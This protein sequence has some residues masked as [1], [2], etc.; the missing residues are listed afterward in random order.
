MKTP[1]QIAA[2][3]MCA[4]SIIDQDEDFNPNGDV[5]QVSADF[6]RDQIIAAIEADRAQRDHGDGEI[7]IVQNDV[8]D[9]VDA[10]RDA[11]EA[12]AA[13]QDGYSIIQETVWEPGEYAEQRIRTLTAAWEESTNWGADEPHRASDYALSEDDWRAGLDD[14]EAAEIARLI[15]WKEEQK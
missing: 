11:D 15:E 4:F 8:G 2:E 5:E 6:I 10:F 14:E 13:Y 3:A 12:T 1:E 7:Y 9:V